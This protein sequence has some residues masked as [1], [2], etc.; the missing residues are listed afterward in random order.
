MRDEELRGQEMGRKR[1]TRRV[2]LLGG[3]Q[4]LV[5]AGLAARMYHL[6]VVE[7][8]QHRAAADRNRFDDSM[9][10]PP[11]GQ[12]VDRF[13]RP[14]AVNKQNYRLFVSR[15]GSPD[16]E[17]TLAQ[18]ARLIDL[19]E[20]RRQKALR[21][22]RTGSRFAPVMVAE[23]LTWDEFALVNANAPALPGVTPDVGWMRDY[24]QKDSCAHVVGYVATPSQQDQEA[25][26][27]NRRLLLL[28][29]MKIG[30]NGVERTEDP[31]LRGKAGARRAEVNVRGQVIR[32]ISRDDGERGAELTLTLDAD[33]QKYAMERMGDYSGSVVVMDV[34][35]GDLIVL[36]SMP[37]YD[38]NP[39]VGGI[40]HAAWRALNEDPLRPLN[41]KAV[42]GSYAPGSTFK[43]IVALA[44]LDS[45]MISPQHTVFCNGR[46]PLGDH[47]FHCWKRG[48]HGAVDMN[49]AI[50]ESCD[51]YFYDVARRMGVDRIAEV[52]RKF[53]VGE[54]PDVALPYVRPGVMPDRAWHLA[55]YGYGWP[56]GQTLN[57]SIGQ[58]YVEMTP[59]QLALMTASFANGG[60]GVTPRLVK[61]IN[62]EEV[63]LEPLVDLGF[64]RAH[65]EAMQRSMDAVCNEQRGTGYN[66]R[67]KLAG[68]EMAGKTGTAQVRRITAAER[69]RRVRANE[70]LP[71]HLRDHALFVAYAPRHDPRYACSIIVEHG[72]GGSAVAAPM[73]RDILTRLM[74]RPPPSEAAGA[75][76]EVGQGRA[77]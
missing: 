37:G 43:M 28:P 62:G 26:P 2:L 52:G 71:R 65:I 56:Q 16:V 24:P 36:A 11:R 50:K 8:P 73:V 70:E 6:Q 72:G 30:K 25:D 15:D 77:G 41:N 44:G 10:A 48:G 29:S 34:R 23:N 66:A 27:E 22:L 42:A 64:R 35:T 60:Y 74:T 51:V 20:H 63:K 21:E 47:I 54:A 17:E 31:I 13:G 61:A 14:L 12:I 32:E 4:G 59:L 18:L 38:P 19:P 53:G 5:G 45:G 33:L 67:I 55:K 69:A 49:R 76:E 7:S 3:V 39:F 40:S 57:V 1:F 75:S 9:I 68:Y 46:M 58:G